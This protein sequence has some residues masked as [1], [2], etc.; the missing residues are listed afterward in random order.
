MI[1]F[2]EESALPRNA[3]RSI[4]GNV[5]RALERAIARG[6][7]RTERD[8]QAFAD[9]FLEAYNTRP[10]SDLGGLSPLQ[11]T[12]LL[13]GEWVTGPADMSDPTDDRPPIAVRLATDI[14]PDALSGAVFLRRARELIAA[15]A[16]S[17]G[18]KATAAG[19]LPRK[20]VGRMLEL[21]DAEYIASVRRY[22]KVINEADNWGLHIT[23]IVVGLAR[24][25]VLRKGVF[26]TTR[27]GRALAAPGRGG[28]L[29][30][31][32]FETY[33]RTFNLA[34]LDRCPEAPAFQQTI[35]YP[36]WRFGQLGG[37]WRTAK[38]WAPLLLLPSVRP[39]IHPGPHGWDPS[40]S[41]VGQRLLRPFVQ[42]GLAE[43]RPCARD[44][45]KAT[46]FPVRRDEYRPTSLYGRFLEFG[47]ARHHGLAP[48]SDWNRAGCGAV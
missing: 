7:V 23:R 39:E 43:A 37:E 5:V 33:F 46:P 3:A 1:G 38:E 27:R 8:V 17:G 13:Y 32:L 20:L 4:S 31:L 36:M 10:Q 24:L 16:A 29:L 47:V 11:A 2:D 34:Y 28:E 45:E 12:R 6:E 35:A 18:V 48:R 19:N 42:F 26:G 21:E 14:E 15:L 30:A 9:R 40:P 44:D 41:L 22:N 25:V